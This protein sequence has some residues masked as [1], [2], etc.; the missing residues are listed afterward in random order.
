[1][2]WLGNCWHQSSISTCSVPVI[3]RPSPVRRDRRPLTTQPSVVGPGRRRAAVRRRS[4]RAPARRGAADRRV[5]GVEDV[6]V[7]AWPGSSGRA[8]ARA[9]RGP[10]SCGRSVRRSAKI[11]GVVSREAVEDLDDPALLGDEDAAVGREAQSGR[12]VE[13]AEDDLVLEAGGHGRRGGRRT[14]QR[15]DGNDAGD[16]APSC[17]PQFHPMPPKNRPTAPRSLASL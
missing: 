16:D 10:S 6:D 4:R 14:E 11:V 9:A 17:V 15:Q 1:M 3:G 5:V 13:A 2:E 12:I 7:R 8:R